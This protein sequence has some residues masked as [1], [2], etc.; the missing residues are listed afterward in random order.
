MSAHRPRETSDAGTLD[1]RPHENVEAA[2]A[3]LQD[4]RERVAL[5]VSQQRQETP[6]I[7]PVP[8]PAAHPIA[9]HPAPLHPRLLT[10]GNFEYHGA[11]RLPKVENDR[12]RFPWGGLSLAFRADGDPQGDDDGYPGSLFTVGHD[13]HQLVAEVSIPI[14]RNLV[15]RKG[16]DLPAASM[17]Q[18]FGDISDGFIAAQSAGTEPFKIGGLFVT[19]D[20]LHWTL[21]K[22]YNVDGARYDSHA[23]SSLNLS[24][25][26][27]EG[28]W[29]LGQLHGGGPE[30]HSYKYAGYIFDVPPRR[31]QND[32]GGLNL[33][34]GL[35]ISTGRQT[36]SQGPAMYAY[37]LPPRGTERGTS[38]EAIPLIYYPLGGGEL[39]HHNAADKWRGGA[40]IQIGDKEGIIIGGRKSLG[41]EYYGEARPSDC[42]PDKGYHGTPYEPQILFYDPEEVLKVARGEQRP[43]SV[44]PWLRWTSE[45]PGGGLKQYFFDTCHA[46]LEGVAFDR[47]NALL[48]L[49]QYGAARI[50]PEDQEMYPI[51]HVFR[52][53]DVQ[54]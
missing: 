53:R 23:T 11:F 50:T 17:L 14:P 20:R 21:F 26:Q 4:A 5:L 46:R 28:L 41:P 52:V 45:T 44:E 32:L 10:P 8:E 51:V 7:E 2:E 19:Q 22:Y 29:H 25:P 33:I 15:D 39:K 48:Y 27:P 42:T 13:Q 37:R 9:R 49:I 12:S 34:S 18:R 54:P 1:V 6:A 47:E 3:R 31:A 35:Q 43:W 36:S 30:W 40:W 38:L 16:A 24:D